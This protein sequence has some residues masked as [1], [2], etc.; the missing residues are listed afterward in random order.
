MN[1]KEPPTDSGNNQQIILPSKIVAQEYVNCFFEHAN[2]TYRYLPQA[3]AYDYLD[4]L[5]DED[6]SLLNNDARMAIILLLMG[7][8]C[9]W[10]ASYRSLPFEEYKIKSHRFLRAGRERLESAT[11]NGGASIELVTGHVLKCQLECAASRF[12]EA[13]MTLGTAIRLAQMIRLHREQQTSDPIHQYCARGLFWAIFMIDRY[14]SVSLGWP[15]ALHE[16]DITIP[17][18]SEPDASILPRVGPQEAKVISGVVAHA[19]LTQIIGH[20]IMKL[21]GGTRI[22]PDSCEQAIT[23]LEGEL[24]KWLQDTPSFF[25]PRGDSREA[26]DQEFYDLPWIFRRQRRTIRSAFHFTKMLIYRGT[27][28]QEFLHHIPSTPPFK[29]PGSKYIQHCADNAWEMANIAADIADDD[30]YN[31]VYWTTSHFIFCAISILLVYHLLYQGPFSRSELERLLERAMKGHGKLDNGPSLI[32]EDLLQ[33]SPLEARPA[34]QTEVPLRDHTN[35]ENAALDP[36]VDRG[37]VETQPLSA[38]GAVSVDTLLPSW[39][40]QAQAPTNTGVSFLIEPGASAGLVHNWFSQG[41]DSST[42][43]VFDMIMDLGFDG[44]YATDFGSNMDYE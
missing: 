5:Y 20:A 41:L 23:Q 19:R 7:I 16:N 3:D 13:W 11:S 32:N 38:H 28:L 18:P 39:L 1:K 25:H 35:T 26:G 34:G 14:L 21:Y 10:L 43:D 15:M 8:G 12:R 6:S 42:G 2:I 9:I 24:D 27:L 37:M 30:T 22:S 17:L 36:V 31:S 44:T 33:K 40:N 29:E 4:Q